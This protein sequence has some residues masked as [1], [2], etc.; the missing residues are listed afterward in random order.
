MRK[1]SGA[2]LGIYMKTPVGIAFGLRGVNKTEKI[3]IP[4]RKPNTR[5][6]LQKRVRNE[7]F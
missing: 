3:R 6:P 5:S 4:E 2:P 1:T 7:I